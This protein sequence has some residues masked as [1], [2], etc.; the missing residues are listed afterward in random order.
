MK[1]YEVLQQLLR[2]LHLSFFRVTSGRTTVRKVTIACHSM[3]LPG[4]VRKM[5]EQVVRVEHQRGGC[6]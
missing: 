1:K 6:G 5:I 4:E 3:V 2:E